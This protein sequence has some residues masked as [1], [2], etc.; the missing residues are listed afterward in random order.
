MVF[1]DFDVTLL[2]LPWRNNGMPE[3]EKHVTISSILVFRKE[4]KKNKKK[5]AD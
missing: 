3:K 1:G 4:E 5:R 2:E